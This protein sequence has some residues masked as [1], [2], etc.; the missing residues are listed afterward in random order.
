MIANTL[1]MSCFY[2]STACAQV[3][4]QHALMLLE[5]DFAIRHLGCKM[6]YGEID[7]NNAC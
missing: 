6:P 4:N 2:S 5:I 3:T 7:N 1:T